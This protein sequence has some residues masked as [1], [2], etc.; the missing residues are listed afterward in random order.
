MSKKN[1]QQKVPKA[2][3]VALLFATFFWLLTKLSK[4]YKTVV[5][6]PVSYVNIPQNKLIQK[7]PLKELQ[8]QVK[9]SGFKLLVL[10]I[11]TKEIQL[12]A[13]RLQK[14]SP[15]EYYFLLQN[16]LLEIQN[17]IS[18]NY[19][20][21]YLVQDTVFLN[22]GTLTSKKIP[23]VGNFDLNYKLGF[24]L[25]KSI[26][27]TPDSI[28]VSGPEAQIDTLN[29]MT[30]ETL[31]ID[32][33]S[34]PID[35]TLKVISPSTNV[36]FN[37][38]EVHVFGEVDRFTEGTIEVPFEIINMPDSVSV[39]TFPTSLKVIFQTGLTNFNKVNSS[40]FKIVCDFQQSI[41]S[42]LSYLIPKVILKPDFVTSVKIIPNKVEYLIQK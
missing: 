15:S 38:K 35:A 11:L 25:A 5:S 24:H 2:F 34:K 20:V 28:L 13:N 27:I 18:N 31:V 32:N 39:N 7:D 14:K 4:E 19:T 23:L 1:N 37:V 30:L 33:I 36:K 6:F 21:D 41:S 29:R 9:S 26:K 16:H 10:Q 17:Q 8:I 12:D 40:S 22:L 42:Q 3:S